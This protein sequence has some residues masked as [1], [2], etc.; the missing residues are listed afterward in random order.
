VLS[1]MSNVE[2]HDLRILDHNCRRVLSLEELVAGSKR[3]NR[4]V[5]TFRKLK[6]ND[7]V[8][9]GFKRPQRS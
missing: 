6:V 3:Y 5:D 4:K 7:V 8:L 9:K 1:L 2:L